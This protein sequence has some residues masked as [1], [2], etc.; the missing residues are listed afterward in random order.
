MSG[1]KNDI[2]PTERA[3]VFLI[4]Q[5]PEEKLENLLQHNLDLITNWPEAISSMYVIEVMLSHALHPEAIYHDVAEEW[6]K[7]KADRQLLVAVILKEASFSEQ[8]RQ[9]I[10]LL[11][12]RYRITLSDSASELWHQLREPQ[13][14]FTWSD[15][16]TAAGLT[17]KWQAMPP[18]NK[19]KLFNAC[20]GLI[21]KPF[22][23]SVPGIIKYYLGEMDLTVL[24]GFRRASVEA[25]LYTIEPVFSLLIPSFSICWKDIFSVLINSDSPTW[26]YEPAE[27]TR[28]YERKFELALFFAEHLDSN[29]N[30]KQK[31]ELAVEL[32]KT[33]DRSNR[34]I[35]LAIKK[36]GMYFSDS[37]ALPAF[38]IRCLEVRESVRG[39]SYCP[40]AFIHSPSDKMEEYVRNISTNLS[41]LLELLP[42][43]TVIKIAKIAQKHEDAYNLVSDIRYSTLGNRG[44]IRDKLTNN[45]DHNTELFSQLIRI[46]LGDVEFLLEYWD[47]SN[48]PST[49]IRI[50][51][52]KWLANQKDIFLNDE[53]GQK[54]IKLI[55]KHKVRARA[56]LRNN[57]YAQRFLSAGYQLK[58]AEITSTKMVGEILP[59]ETEYDKTKFLATSIWRNENWRNALVNSGYGQQFIVQS[60]LASAPAKSEEVTITWLQE[61]LIPLCQKQ[62]EF[63]NALGLIAWCGMEEKFKCS[64]RLAR[65]LILSNPLY[66]RWEW[67]PEVVKARELF[68]AKQWKWLIIHEQDVANLLFSLDKMRD[69]FFENYL[70]KN[71]E[72][73]N[74][75]DIPKKWAHIFQT[76]DVKS[77]LLTWLLKNEHRI[78]SSDWLRWVKYWDFHSDTR[79]QKRISSFIEQS[80]GKRD[81][82]TRLLALSLLQTA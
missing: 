67:D 23:D 8:Q 53:A 28:Y 56:G 72:D 69:M 68:A 48:S 78:R 32:T 60:I 29:W 25:S 57:Y 50:D 24:S 16:R 9:R 31:D 74:W 21:R 27:L 81:D 70:D 54:L 5:T 61:V 19:P 20:R 22:N 6:L 40:E 43:K 82:E 30:Q 62:A 64:D 44:S 58:K 26:S 80:Q 39:D 36:F 35:L 1:K 73:R 51:L 14:N 11:L 37:Q 55:V 34:W 3:L 18:K 2:S 71:G 45:H 38:L 59:S 66:Q 42:I 4:D 63:R 17:G 76:K 75:L 13:T 77:R 10:L 46:G 41:A 7:T 49:Q 12:D 52:D 79:V 15:I 47:E 65:F 33:L